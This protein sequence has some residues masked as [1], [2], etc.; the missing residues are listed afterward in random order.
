[1]SS[2]VTLCGPVRCAY[3]GC[4]SQPSC[5]VDGVPICKSHRAHA[6]AGARKS[7]KVYEIDPSQLVD[8][9]SDKW[10][11]I[12]SA[13]A[14]VDHG[15]GVECGYCGADGATHKLDGVFLCIDCYMTAFPPMQPKKTGS[16]VAVKAPSWSGQE[17]KKKKKNEGETQIYQEKPRKIRLPD[18]AD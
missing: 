2:N 11:C 13:S 8:P 14:R 3:E 17:K 7:A 1:M 5:T 12:V 18:D 4:E 6:I 10:S 16:T 15:Q 9:S